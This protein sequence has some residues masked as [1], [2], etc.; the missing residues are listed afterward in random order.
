MRKLRGDGVSIID[1]IVVEIAIVI[2]IIDISI[3]GRGA[4]QAPSRQPPKLA[5]PYIYNL[6][7]TIFNFSPY[8]ESPYLDSLFSYHSI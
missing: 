6:I 7:Y 2:H 4:G 5:Y 8:G 1:I 3:T